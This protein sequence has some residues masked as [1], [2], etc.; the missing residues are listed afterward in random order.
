MKWH[1][2][3]VTY[4]QPLSDVSPAVPRELSTLIQRM[5]AKDSAARLSSVNDVECALMQLQRRIQTTEDIEV[6]SLLG[7]APASA[8]DTKARK[9]HRNALRHMLLLTCVLACAGAAWWLLGTASRTPPMMARSLHWVEQK[10]AWARARVD[11]LRRL[12]SRPSPVLAARIETSSG[13]MVLVP[14]GRFV[15]GSSAVLN[16]T[17]GHTVYLPAFYIG[18]V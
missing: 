8:P 11:E 15:I 10:V 12:A 4:L 14:A 16:E 17:P 3:P 6:A 2:D 13:P 1:A 9:Q 7:S 18:H 5:I